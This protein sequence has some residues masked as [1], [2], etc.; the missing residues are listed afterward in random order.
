MKALAKILTGALVLSACSP[1]ADTVGETAAE[2]E[3]TTRVVN[4]YSSR[5]YSSD[6]AIYAAF[7]EETGIEVNLIEAGGDT[8]IERVRAD[9]ERSPADV[10]VTVDAARLHRADEAGLFA[11]TDF[12]AL[13]DGVDE[14]LIHPEG[15]WVA[16]S[17]RARVIAYASN[18]VEA[19]EITSYA[20]LADP[21]WQGRICIRSSGNVYNQSLLAGLIARDGE[22]AAQAWAQGIVDNM[23]REPQGGD[24]DQLRGIAAGD[25][26]VAVVNHY[27]YALLARSDDP[28]NA[29][30]ANGIELVFPDQE[31]GG[32]HV[33]ISGVGIAVNAP[34][35]AEA[36]ALVE[37]FLSDFSQRAFVEMT[38]EIPVI[39]NTQWDNPVVAGFL[40][41]VEDSRNVNELGENN[42]T[43]QRVFDRVGWQ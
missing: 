3:T 36:Q 8:L 32:T 29:A 20:D 21:A 23:A 13:L 6:R 40:P 35:P 10:I 19:G 1:A 22:D 37:F 25:C 9:G 42:A 41:F 28:A 2:T 27:Y 34:H 18:R 14:H 31:T 12:S 33:N 24:T 17:K 4:V 26:D 39:E 15:H 43:A 38:N 30:V 11:P 5:H 16:V 7:T